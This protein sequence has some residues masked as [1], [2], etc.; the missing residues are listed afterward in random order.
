MSDFEEA[1]RDAQEWKVECRRL[2]AERDQLRAELAAIKAQEPVGYRCW[3]NK[4]PEKIM[5][6]WGRTPP[7]GR[8]NAAATYQ[9]LYAAPVAKQVVMPVLPPNIT[10]EWGDAYRRGWLSYEREYSRLNAADQEGGV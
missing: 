7:A 3:F 10:G 2:E 4:E 9:A 5:A 1:I 6:E 8:L